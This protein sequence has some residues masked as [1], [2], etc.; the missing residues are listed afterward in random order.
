M[1]YG[2]RDQKPY[3]FVLSLLKFPKLKG[4]SKKLPAEVNLFISIENYEVS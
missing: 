1:T 2:A 3:G 4:M